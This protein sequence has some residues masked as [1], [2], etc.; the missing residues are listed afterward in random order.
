MHVTVSQMSVQIEVLL[1]QK[2]FFVCYFHH[3]LSPRLPLESEGETWKRVIGSDYSSSS[4]SDGSQF[5][6]LFF[7]V[8][9]FLDPA[10]QRCNNGTAS[11]GDVPGGCRNEGLFLLRFGQNSGTV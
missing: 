10:M 5:R 1:K 9:L 11:S 2:I 3:L 7:R 4:A 6:A 8:P